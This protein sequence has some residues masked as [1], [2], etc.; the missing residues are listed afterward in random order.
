MAQFRVFKSKMFGFSM[1]MSILFIIVLVVLIAVGLYF[2]SAPVLKG[3]SILDLIVSKEWK[4]S[5]GHF[6]FLPFIMGTLWVT[7]I[8][9]VLAVPLCLL[10]SIYISEYAPRN[11][12]AIMNP[13]IDLLSGIPP[14]VYGVW[15]ILV[16]V[17]F[18]GDHIAPHFAT[19][20]S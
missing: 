16:I 9:I 15:G 2:K 7:G 13:M 11:V 1:R 18:V 8:A 10:T 4:P 3:K 19:F 5:K 14:V 12:L 17:P 6:G 20:S